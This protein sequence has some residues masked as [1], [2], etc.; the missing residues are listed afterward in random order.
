MMTSCPAGVNGNRNDSSARVVY[1]MYLWEKRRKNGV[2]G[3]ASKG[4]IA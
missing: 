1:Y 4:H 3:V 2:C